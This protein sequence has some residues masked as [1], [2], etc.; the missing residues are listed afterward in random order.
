VKRGMGVEN[1]VRAVGVLATGVAVG[2]QVGAVVLGTP[3]AATNPGCSG[4]VAVAT[5][6]RGT[7]GRQAD[8]GGA[9][10]TLEF[11]ETADAIYGFARRE[12]GGQVWLDWSSTGGDGWTR[13]DSTTAAQRT[14]DDP[15]WLLRA[16]GR[17]GDI[18]RCTD[19]F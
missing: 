18:I 8:L 5:D 6:Q 16:C 2:I 14:T 9:T 1:V 12:G 15:Q 10:V 19:W 7:I 11:V 17:A 13:C 3:A 4:F